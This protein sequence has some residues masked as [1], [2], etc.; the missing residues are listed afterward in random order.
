MQLTKH[1]DFAFRTLI[2]LASMPTESTTIQ[3]VAD[4]FDMPKS[5]LMKVVST[6][7]ANGYVHSIRGKQ[8]GISLAKTP[9]EITLREVLE[10]MEK[11]LEPLDCVGQDCLILKTCRLK[12]TLKSAQDKYLVHLGGYSIADMVDTPTINVIHLL[13]P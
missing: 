2:Y 3:D 9:E 7:V 10:L 12:R 6:L 1:T 8:G 13:T 4:R 11:T 5:H